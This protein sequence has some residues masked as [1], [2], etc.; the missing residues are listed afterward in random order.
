MDV[1]ALAL[2]NG[3]ST[4]GNIFLQNLASFGSKSQFLANVSYSFTFHRMSSDLL[5]Q[6]L[7]I[8][9]RH[10]IS[11]RFVIEHDNM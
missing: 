9:E 5:A 8:S 3:T 4:A 10:S 6:F 1:P 7:F 11:T 2:K